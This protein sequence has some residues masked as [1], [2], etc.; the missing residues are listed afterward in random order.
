[1]PNRAAFSANG[2]AGAGRRAQGPEGLAPRAPPQ[3]DK[4]ARAAR[5]PAPRRGAG[6]GGARR[7]LT[8]V[9]ELLHGERRGGEARVEVHLLRDAA[10]GG[11]APQGAQQPHGACPGPLSPARP[12]F[13]AAPAPPA[14]R[15][16]RGLLRRA[17]G[18]R[19]RRRWVPPPGPAPRSSGG[20]EERAAPTEGEGGERRAARVGAWSSPVPAGWARSRVGLPPPA[21]VPRRGGARIPEGPGLDQV[22]ARCPGARRGSRRGRGAATGER[23][24][25]AQPWRLGRRCGAGGSSAPRGAPG[26]GEPKP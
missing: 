16:G 5:G 13:P 6:P 9:Q 21:A 23:G 24:P 2:A 8:E 19:C 1:M 25:S 10:R 7:G 11:A 26:E 3:G 14:P 20:A 18:R 17:A 12:P 22:G 15:P 4:G